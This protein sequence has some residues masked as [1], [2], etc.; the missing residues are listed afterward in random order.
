MA[1]EQHNLSAQLD[2]TTL[3]TLIGKIEM[4]EAY[5]PPRVAEMARKMGSKAGWSLD[6]T[7]CDDDGKGMGFQQHRD[8]K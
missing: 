8:A 1:R 5:N 2:A 3:K 4:A 6:I 7:T